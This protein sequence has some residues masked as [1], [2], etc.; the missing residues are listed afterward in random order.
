MFSLA[1]ARQYPFRVSF[2]ASDADDDAALAQRIINCAP[3]RDTAAEAVAWSLL[4]EFYRE[5]ERENEAEEA[6]KRAAAIYRAREIFVH[7]AREARVK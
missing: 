4:A 2:E 1:T 6:D 7:G 3:V 5:S